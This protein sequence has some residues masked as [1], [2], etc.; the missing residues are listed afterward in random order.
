MN[1]LFTLCLVCAFT[2]IIK[3]QTA[4]PQI[5]K[6]E[7]YGKVSQEDLDLKTLLYNDSYDALHDFYKCTSY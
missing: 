5:P 1:K 6:T 7:E 2:T 3:A 4:S